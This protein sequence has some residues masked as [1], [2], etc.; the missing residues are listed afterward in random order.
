MVRSEAEEKPKARIKGLIRFWT[1][2]ENLWALIKL[3][4]TGFCII[5]T[6]FSLLWRMNKGE[7][8]I[9]CEVIAIVQSQ[10]R[11]GMGME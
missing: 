4:C 5:R 3:H 2:I 8:E 1:L 10:E 9:N 6:A 11:K 7:N